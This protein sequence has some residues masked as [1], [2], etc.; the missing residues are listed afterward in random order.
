M[1]RILPVLA[2]AVFLF[3]PG[4]ASAQLS[5][6]L[7]PCDGPECQACHVVELGQNILNF[8]VAIAAFVAVL[9]FSYAGI[10]ML[11]AAGN[12]GQ[13]SKA[14]GMFGNV[15]I[16]IIIVLAGWLIVD[17]VMKQAFVESDLDESTRST[18]GPWN[19]INCVE[20]PQYESEGIGDY[21]I[22]PPPE[23]EAGDEECERLCTPAALTERY[24]GS[25]VAREAPGLRTM[26]NCYLADPRV[27]EITDRNQLYTT[28]RTYPNCALTNGTRVP[29]CGISR[30]S[31][32]V[33]STHYGRGSG[34]GARA[35][36]FNAVNNNLEAELHRRLQ[37][38]E[39]YCGGTLLFEGS[40]THISL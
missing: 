36:D 1:Y 3:L 12:E 33:N 14:R 34:E 6:P 25:P 8:L 38:R 2:A 11:T 27:A 28:D 17:T 18:F 30:C 22:P 16:G 40:H 9:I 21:V 29:Q 24:G 31:H 15:V 32:S 4:A 26:I 19:Q 20:L 35:V 23:C 39:S 37:V 13:I 7:V 5:G 10:L